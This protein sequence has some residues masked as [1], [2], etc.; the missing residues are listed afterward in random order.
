MSNTETRRINASWKRRER[1]RDRWWRVLPALGLLV[2]VGVD[3]LSAPL[4][5]EV[6]PVELVGH[7]LTDVPH[8][9]YVT[10]FN[11]DEQ[12]DAVINLAVHPE[13]A[14]KVCDV[15]VVE[16][17]TD[18]EWAGAPTLLEVR[19]GVC[20]VMDPPICVASTPPCR[21]TFTQETLSEGIMRLAGPNQLS[22]DA[23]PCLVQPDQTVKCAGLGR[24]YDVVFDCADVEPDGLLGPGDFIDGFGDEAGFYVVHD[25]TEY[26]LQTE[27]AEVYEIASGSQNPYGIPAEFFSERTV[28][29]SNIQDL[30]PAPLVVISHGNGHDFAWYDYLQAHLASYGYVVMSHQ[31]NTIPG[32]SAAADT[33]LRHTDAFLG[34]VLGNGCEAINPALCDMVDPTRIVWIGH[35]RGGEGAAIAHRRLREGSY[36]PVNYTVDSIRVVSSMAGS[37]NVGMDAELRADP[38]TVPFHLIY[39]AADSDITGTAGIDEEHAFHIFERAKGPRQSVYIHGVG[40]AW[41]HDHAISDACDVCNESCGEDCLCTGGCSAKLFGPSRISQDETHKIVTGYYVPLLKRYLEDNIP[42]EDFLWRPW[43]SFR[44][45]L[46]D[47]SNVVVLEY[48][49]YF[50]PS[51]FIVDDFKSWPSPN[52]SS[53]GGAVT[54]S[55]DALQEGVTRDEDCTFDWDPRGSPNRCPLVCESTASF[56]QAFNGMTRGRSDETDHR[57]VVFEWPV[58][59]VSPPY[60]YALQIVPAGRNQEQSR[61]LSFRAAQMP[62][63][64]QTQLELGDLDLTV[65][66]RDGEGTTAS[67]GTGAYGSGV[68]EPYLREDLV[69][70][71]LASCELDPQNT[72]SC[73]ENQTCLGTC[74]PFLDQGWQAEFETIRI[75]LLDFQNAAPTLDLSDIVEVEFL[76]GGSAGSSR[77]RLALDDIKFTSR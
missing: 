54:Y 9:T 46:A 63:H 56:Q 3:S 71:V 57:A 70:T 66:L 10:A 7:R 59:G 41:F 11:E 29:P 37:D 12:V 51:S 62:R 35:S 47:G 50:D 15:Y 58:A 44:P 30:A 38:G 31:N 32:S 64:L 76:F 21:C 72:C 24:G 20:Q 43:E 8:F 55:V 75:P 6:T 36:V 27:P 45:K 22:S 25:T 34:A 49:N 60:S 52:V 73:V 48:D 1:Q 16:A 5:S 65:I 4:Q 77:G 61:F 13:I 67:I 42:A 2:G 18:A 33:T 39:G 26:R 17:K 68:E 14:G 23:E 28:F 40:H 69:T 74:E 53:S 19:S